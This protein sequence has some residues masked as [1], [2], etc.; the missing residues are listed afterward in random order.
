VNHL[1]QPP[2]DRRIE[3]PRLPPI[4]LP[5]RP[6]IELPRLEAL[7][8]APGSKLVIG[9]LGWAVESIPKGERRHCFFPTGAED[10]RFRG[11][12]TW[13]RIRITAI[14]DIRA[15]TDI[16]VVDDKGHVQ[17]DS[18][19]FMVKVTKILSNS[20][21]ILSDR[22]E[23]TDVFETI[24]Y[25]KVTGFIYADQDI[26]VYVDQSIDGKNWDE[27][28]TAKRYTGESNDCAFSVEIAMPYV[29]V[30]FTNDSG[31]DTEECRK[32]VQL[33]AGY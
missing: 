12:R 23:I 20:D 32:F 26:Y 31:T 13:E 25:N 3:L 6:P 24:G 30:R 15:Y 4:P 28:T 7:P 21:N 14:E 10:G 33:S 29:R 22:T 1:D 5:P 18:Q 9:M 2:R 16:F 27:V 11:G 19:L 17:A 8:E